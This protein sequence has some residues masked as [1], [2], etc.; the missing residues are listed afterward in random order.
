[1]GKKG[2]FSSQGAGKKTSGDKGKA[3]KGAGGAGTAGAA[4]AKKKP[5]KKQTRPAQGKGKFRD[6]KP[7]QDRQVHKPEVVAD[8]KKR[9]RPAADALPAAAP[10]RLSKKK[11]ESVH[12]MNRLEHDGEFKLAQIAKVMWEKARVKELDAKQRSEIITELL[13]K[14]SGHIQSLCLKHDASRIV[15]T[16]LKYGTKSQCDNICTELLGTVRMLCKSKYGKA[17]VKKLLTYCSKPTRAEIIRSELSGHVLE[18]VAHK[19]AAEIVEYVYAE[20]ATGE[21]KNAMHSE[22]Y[23]REF[24]VQKHTA[25][26]K[27]LDQLSPKMLPQVLESM[28]ALVHKLVDKGIVGHSIVHRCAHDF[29]RLATVEQKASFAVHVAERLLEMIHTRSGML[30]GVCCVTFGSP[31]D[32][33][34]IIKSMREYISKVSTEEF[35]HLVLIQLLSVVDDT[36]LLRDFVI[37]ELAAEVP[38]LLEDVYARR[39]LLAVLSPANARYFPGDALAVLK[40][41]LPADFV[42]SKKSVE[43]RTA[44][45]LPA[46]LPALLESFE[47][48][49]EVLFNGL[50]VGGQGTAVDVLFETVEA[51]SD[52]SSASGALAA[53]A[54]HVAQIQ[55][56]EHPERLRAFGSVKRLLSGTAGHF[57]EALAKT[58]GSNVLSYTE[59]N[60]GGYVVAALLK[61][62]SDSVKATLRKQVQSAKAS[63]KSLPDD[64]GAKH[65]LAECAK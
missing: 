21:Q 39:V 29:L 4:A 57:A 15:Q 28:S 59:N 38:T 31:K 58:I 40:P 6:T 13:G 34:Q 65:L 51:C 7:T 9:K 20:I 32:R 11:K 23:G 45:L 25:A 17:L 10:L 33:K 52:E 41:E 56:H 14:L 5:T 36:V 8:G 27:T 50:E 3:K 62:C 35:G 12:F 55:W 64:S 54:E 37:K 46:L 24:T 60:S 16:C 26:I 49:P 19:E 30:V 42:V 1:M 61:S 43:Q 2:G 63:L 18:L 22:L 44:E 53:V 47:E 48:N